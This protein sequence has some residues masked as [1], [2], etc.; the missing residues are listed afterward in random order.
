[1]RGLLF[2]GVDLINKGHSA[3]SFKALILRAFQKRKK[4]LILAKGSGL[5]F[6]RTQ[7]KIHFEKLAKFPLC[8]VGTGSVT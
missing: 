7:P 1:M 6:R 8:S 2:K 4:S 5:D 3:Y